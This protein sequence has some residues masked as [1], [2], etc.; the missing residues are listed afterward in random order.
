MHTYRCIIYAHIHSSPFSWPLRRVFL[1]SVHL[2]GLSDVS[3]LGKEWGEDTQEEGPGPDPW[4][5]GLGLQGALVGQGDRSR[6]Q[7]GV[8]GPRV[9]GASRGGATVCRGVLQRA[10]LG[11]MKGPW[12]G[13]VVR[14][15]EAPSP[16]PS[17]GEGGKGGRVQGRQG[18]R[19]VTAGDAGMRRTRGGPA[20]R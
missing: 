19:T 1:D 11:R 10:G 7:G 14:S 17:G 3:L 12:S 2:Q 9:C 8:A 20:V 6:C 13:A 4:N 16:S 15:Q 18:A 5:V